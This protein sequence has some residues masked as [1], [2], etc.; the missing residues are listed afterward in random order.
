MHGGLPDSHI[1]LI[2][3]GDGEPLRECHD[4]DPG[5][6]AESERSGPHSTDDKE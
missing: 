1:T 3:D 6:R 4:Y 2:K 5:G